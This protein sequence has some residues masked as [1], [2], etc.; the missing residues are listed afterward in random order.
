MEVNG[1]TGASVL[2]QY[3]GLISVL[4]ETTA[5]TP[6]Q[7]LKDMIGR[8]IKQLREYQ[9]ES[10]H[11][12]PIMMATILNPRLRL[13]HF[14]TR[15]PDYA[16]RAE[17]LFRLQFSQYEQRD[18]HLAEATSQ[19]ES[20]ADQIIDPLDKTNVFS[21][22]NANTLTSDEELDQ[23]FSG[24]HPCEGDTDILK[25]WRVSCSLCLFFSGVSTTTKNIT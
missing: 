16:V 23:Y 1:P 19:A 10:L 15:N 18:P 7:G 8:M 22:S 13:E 2:F 3:S 24:M 25:W 11:C 17:E 5:R 20:D 9:K 4:T 14:K 12:D 21:T 6:H